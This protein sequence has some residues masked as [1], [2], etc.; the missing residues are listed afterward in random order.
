MTTHLCIQHPYHFDDN[1][2]IY[3]YSPKRTEIFLSKILEEIIYSSNEMRFTKNN[4]KYFY[5]QDLLRNDL[6]EK[7]LQICSLLRIT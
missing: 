2:I 1:R 4:N 5:K 3:L 6:K 7:I